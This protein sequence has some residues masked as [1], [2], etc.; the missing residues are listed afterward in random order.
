M[1]KIEAVPY[2]N[3]QGPI[4]ETTLLPGDPLR[5]RFIAET[6]LEDARQF[7]SVRNMLD[8]TGYYRGTQVSIM[9][10][11]TGIPSVSPYA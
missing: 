1:S 7:N 11:D 6:Y 10:S 9:G 5:A 4:A 3:P 2:I 8:F